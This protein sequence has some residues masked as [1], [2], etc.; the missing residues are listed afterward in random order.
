MYALQ[1]SVFSESLPVPSNSEI[2]V[3][4]QNMESALEIMANR[5]KARRGFTLFTINLDHLVKLKEDRRFRAAYSRAD[6]VSADGWP[7][8]WLLRQQGTLVKRTTGADLVEPLCARAAKEGLPLFF[9]GPSYAS[10]RKALDILIKRYPGLA[11]A[12]ADT[13]HVRVDRIE[14]TAK[15]FAQRIKDSGARIC[16]LSLGAPKQEL[17]AEA[18][19]RHCPE[20]GFICV[21]AALDFISGN[22]VRAPRG[23]QMAGLEWFWRL[24]NDPRR[25]TARYAQCS[26]LF[27]TLAW[28]ALANKNRHSDVRNALP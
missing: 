23:V 19:L 1:S 24:A 13:P 18:L 9:I 10:Q 25:L 26:M 6:L 17:L 21:G 12:G 27:A 3:N 2:S 28:R 11:I 5:A 22:M 16:V 20:V 7:I 4:L 15:A 14:E 8:V